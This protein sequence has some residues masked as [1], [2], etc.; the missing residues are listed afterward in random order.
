M[1]ESLHLHALQGGGGVSMSRAPA[2]RPSRQTERTADGTGV[3]CRIR[4]VNAP[5][6]RVVEIHRCPP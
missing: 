5:E 1:S 2:R 3:A 4:I 6:P